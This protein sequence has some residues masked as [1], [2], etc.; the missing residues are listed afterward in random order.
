MKTIKNLF[1]EEQSYIVEYKLNDKYYLFI[2]ALDEFG[3]SIQEENFNQYAI[4]ENT[5]VELCSYEAHDTICEWY[6]HCQFKA[7]ETL[8]HLEK[9]MEYAIEQYESEQG[10]EE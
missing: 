2:E 6:S 4:T 10:D 8:E 7:F 3:G 5:C 9:V 1:I